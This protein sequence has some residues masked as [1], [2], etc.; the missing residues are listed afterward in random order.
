VRD[1]GRELLKSAEDTLA[2]TALMSERLKA[3]D[4]MPLDF[5]ATFADAWDFYAASAEARGLRCALDIDDDLHVLA[6]KRTLRQV[7]INLVADAVD[8]AAPGSTIEVTA[9]GDHDLVELHVASVSAHPRTAP[10]EGSL[11][12]CL[13][14]AML[15]LQGSS[16]LELPGEGGRRIVVAVFDRAAQRDLFA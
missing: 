12:L 6:E 4:L 5:A 7:L 13:A 15:E 1:C 3:S 2:M 16:L 10:A 11:P 14:N 9:R 8:S